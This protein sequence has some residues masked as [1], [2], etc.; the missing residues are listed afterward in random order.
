[1]PTMHYRS[2]FRKALKKEWVPFPGLAN[3]R[4]GKVSMKVGANPFF[5]MTK[6]NPQNH[7]TQQL[8]NELRVLNKGIVLS[9]T[10]KG[11]PVVWKII[12]RICLFPIANFH[13]FQFYFYKPEGF[14]DSTGEDYQVAD[15]LFGGFLHVMGKNQGSKKGK[16]ALRPILG[17]ALFVP[18]DFSPHFGRRYI[19]PLTFITPVLS[20]QFLSSC[21]HCLFCTPS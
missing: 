14:S 8:Y 9:A 18:L 15:L 13:N 1:M 12:I 4:T 7:P 16:S 17:G 3:S 2:I 6:V 20:K 10:R 5:S 19:V 11:R 21:I